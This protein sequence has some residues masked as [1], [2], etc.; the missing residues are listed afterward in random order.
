MQN[1]NK[2][3]TNTQN[4]KTM[5]P[6][7]NRSTRWTKN[8]ARPELRGVQNAQRSYERYLALAQAEELRGK[9]VGAE[10]YYHH[11]EHYFRLM[12]SDMGAT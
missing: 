9:T 7:A 3:M 12:S 4:P 8:V 2:T 11:D 6:F 5:K 1:G 10:N